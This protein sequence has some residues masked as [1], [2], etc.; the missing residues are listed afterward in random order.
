M[1]VRLHGSFVDWVGLQTA[2]GV[3][4]LDVE[5]LQLIT[6]LQTQRRRRDGSLTVE[7]ADDD[8]LILKRWATWAIHVLTP[9][10]ANPGPARGIWNS[11]TALVRQIDRAREVAR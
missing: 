4:E 11:A 6:A 9:K 3:T 2:V 10:K 1:K 7:L 5:E 8:V